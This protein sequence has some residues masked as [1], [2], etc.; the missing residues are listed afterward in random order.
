MAL[1][2]I[3]NSA[4]IIFNPVNVSVGIVIAGST[5]YLLKRLADGNYFEYISGRKKVDLSTKPA[6]FRFFPYDRKKDRY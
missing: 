1:D 5:L 6:Y 3:M 2:E 4:K